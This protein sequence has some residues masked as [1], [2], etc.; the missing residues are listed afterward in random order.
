M[1]KWI[2]QEANLFRSSYLKISSYIYTLSIILNLCSCS[3]EITDSAFGDYGVDLSYS[4]PMTNDGSFAGEIVYDFAG[5][6]AGEAAG[7][8]AGAVAGQGMNAPDDILCQSTTEI[9]DNIYACFDSIIVPESESFCNL[10]EAIEDIIK[11]AILLSADRTD[12]SV[13]CLDLDDDCSY[14]C[15]NY[16]L[17]EQLQDPDDYRYS[18]QPM[19]DRPTHLGALPLELVENTLSCFTPSLS[20]SPSNPLSLSRE[21]CVFVFAEEE[22]IQHFQSSSGDSYGWFSPISSPLGDTLKVSF[23]K[24]EV[25]ET[26]PV[27]VSHEFGN[28]SDSIKE[29]SFVR[30]QGGSFSYSFYDSTLNKLYIDGSEVIEL[31][32][33]HD[34][35]EAML[36]TEL[37]QGFPELRSFRATSDGLQWFRLE[38]GLTSDQIDQRAL[39]TRFLSEQLSF[40]TID[41][42]SISQEIIC[43]ECSFREQTIRIAHLMDNGIVRIEEGEVEQTI[44]EQFG[45][46]KQIESSQN[47]LGLVPDITIVNQLYFSLW[48]DPFL[49]EEGELNDDSLINF[50]IILNIEQYGYESVELHSIK[51]MKALVRLTEGQAAN[52]E[53]DTNQEQDL[54]SLWGIYYVLNDHLLVLDLEELSSTLSTEVYGIAESST[55]WSDKP[56]LSENLLSWP[57]QKDGKSLLLI[58][59]LNNE[60]E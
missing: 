42:R 53:L 36:P 38:Y 58:I 25:D 43:V 6:T 4:D 16:R 18:V 27:L 24:F 39:V 5:E 2:K 8:A 33:F 13:T 30:N 49:N 37:F 57:Y 1:N 23:T 31:E 50:P 20:T 22:R 54:K 52:N 29:M 32:D 7:E 40:R 21:L 41:H 44:F 9:T 48:S 34:S 51:G 45:P 35:L 12:V 60:L 55:E 19:T 3:P 56:I 26:E 10:E 28:S 14:H 59:D 47:L 46:F 15:E 17:P 11:T